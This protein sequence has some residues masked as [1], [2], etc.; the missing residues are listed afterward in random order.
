MAD[1]VFRISHVRPQ[2]STADNDIRGLTYEISKST[3][4]KFEIYPDNSLGDSI[5]VQRKLSDGSVEMALQP[6]SAEQD[7]RFKI[8]S[9]PY[10]VSDWKDARSK[11]GKGGNVRKAIED[12][13]ER[14]GIQVLAVYPQYFGGVSLEKNPTATDRGT[15][16]IRVPKSQPYLA[17]SLGF[18]PVELAF[19]DINKSFKAGLI[20]GIIG[21]GA[22]G[23][24][25]SFL[26]HT[27]YYVVANTHFEVWY[28]LMN[29]KKFDDL[30]QRYK[31]VFLKAAAYFEALR[32]S[33]ADVLQAFNEMRLRDSGVVMIR[34][35]PRELEQTASEARRNIWPAIFDEIGKPYAERILDEI[36]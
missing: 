7:N 22:E 35:T 17:Q 12:L 3:N 33:R 20:D 28:L 18:K 16:R 15:I 2:G 11:F 13:F 27:K 26:D 8:S 10:L 23:Y 32:W 21:S 4:L 36:K 24:Y 31:D 1:P 9:L 19:S 5:A 30:P 34:P 14:Q 29:K 6:I 25:V